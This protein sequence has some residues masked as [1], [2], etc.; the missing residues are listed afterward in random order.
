[1]TTRNPLPDILANMPDGFGRVFHPAIHP[2]AARPIQCHRRFL[3]SARLGWHL[4]SWASAFEI[5]H[6][7][8]T[9]M[10][11][12]YS[13]LSPETAVQAARKAAELYLAEHEAQ[14]AAEIEATAAEGGTSSRM[15]D[16]AKQRKDLSV[17]VA[18]GQIFMNA[19][20]LPPQWRVLFVE[21]TFG[22]G[23]Q[24]VG[25]RIGLQEI[26]LKHVR[27]ARL[28]LEGTL[29]AG[30]MHPE[31]SWGNEAETYIHDH[32]TTAYSPAI[33]AA[34]LTFDNQS[35]LY[36]ALLDGWLAEQGLP[37]CRGVVHNII[38]KPTIRLKKDE[39]Y[40]EYVDRCFEQYDLTA[41]K[42][43]HNPPMDRSFVSFLRPPL[44]DDLELLEVLELIAPYY[45]RE[46]SL[47]GFPRCGSSYVC[48]SRGKTCPYLPLC[49]IENPGAWYGTLQRLRFTKNDPD[50][51]E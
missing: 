31:P 39:T 13:G 28:R 3:F 25:L 7:F 20:P 42:D 47:I 34:T 12:Q 10:Q 26:G 50:K 6:V 21:R 46:P 38:Q 29:D 16:H 15:P 35:L 30:V 14:L 45:V 18:L 24:E 22:M 36:R 2:S 40:E 32:K 4:P 51:R 41:L 33:R 11:G 27:D 43:P 1:M 44:K 17:G 19:F 23:L 5:G 49:Q 9:V 37:P 48:S 8:H